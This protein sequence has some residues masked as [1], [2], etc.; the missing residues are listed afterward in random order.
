MVSA[1]SFPPQMKDAMI[2][3]CRQQVNTLAPCKQLGIVLCVDQSSEPR[4]SPPG[5]G[6]PKHE[7]LI[8]RLLFTLRRWTSSRETL[9]DRFRKE[10]ESIRKLLRSCDADSGAR[11]VLIARPAGLEDSSRYWS[12]WMT[13]DHLRI[14]NHGMNRVI[15]ALA[16]G[17]VPP[18]VAS[19][20][21]VKPSPLATS[22]V[23]DEYESSC[24]ALLA[25]VAAVANL[26]TEVRYAHPWFGPLDAAGWHALAAGHLGI[27]R[28]QI[29][30]IIRELRVTE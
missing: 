27:H 11:R 16:K 13:L 19:T 30:R 10:R 9:N 6:L 8:G 3:T 14:V 29:E 18:G 12:I 2:N 20:A 15:G 7:L 5:A 28:V 22:Y 17:I 25:A 4:L 23:V 26:R 24:D 1:A 21:T